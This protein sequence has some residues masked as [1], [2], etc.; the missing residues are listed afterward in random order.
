MFQDFAASEKMADPSPT[1]RLSCPRRFAYGVGHVLN[2]LCASMWFSYLLVFY[3]HVIQ[4]SNEMSGYLM[5]LGQVADAIATPLVGYESDRTKGL[6]GYTKRKSWHLFGMYDRNIFHILLREYRG[7]KSYVWGVGYCT[8]ISPT[9]LL[10]AFLTT[11]V[12]RHINYLSQTK[13]LKSSCRPFW[14]VKLLC[15]VG[16][17]LKSNLII[18]CNRLL[19]LFVN[20]DF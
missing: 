14:I 11:C 7:M 20:F 19:K 12:N 3:H 8:I 10:L 1:Y 15:T 18:S 13:T 4:F 17:I 2:D 6:C 16:R 9:D 5:L